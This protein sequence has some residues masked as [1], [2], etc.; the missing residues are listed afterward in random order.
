MALMCLLCAAMFWAGWCARACRE[1]AIV[2]AVME[3]F[4]DAARDEEGT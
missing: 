4:E 1:R 2:N 3:G